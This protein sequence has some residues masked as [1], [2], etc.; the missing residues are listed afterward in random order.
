M[1]PVQ[2]G[3]PTLYYH[4][5]GSL[6]AFGLDRHHD[7][8]D[9]LVRLHVAVRLDDLL[10][11][12]RLGDHRLELTSRQTLDDE[13]LG[14]F[15]PPG[16]PGD[17]EQ[18]VAADGQPKVVKMNS[19]WSEMLFGFSLVISS[20]DVG[21]WTAYPRTSGIANSPSPSPSPPHGGEGKIIADAAQRASR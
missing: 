3:R 12:E 19:Q 8:A 18:D 17:L 4:R 1:G 16:I 20:G 14:L 5:S 6:D 9:L 7:F 2:A 15:E 11:R 10:E 13:L 21:L